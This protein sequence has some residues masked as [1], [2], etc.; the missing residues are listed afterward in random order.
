MKAAGQWHVL[1]V[2]MKGD[3]IECFLDAKK[4]LD[5]KD[6]TFTSAGAVGFWTKSDAQTHFDNL[7]IKER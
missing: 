4:H 6:S 5:A 7:T 2:V 3:H 1:K